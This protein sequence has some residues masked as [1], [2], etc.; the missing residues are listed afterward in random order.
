MHQF[1]RFVGQDDSKSGIDVAIA[2]SGPQ[3][4]VRHYG[5]ITDRF[6]VLLKPVRRLGPR[7]NLLFGT[8]AGPCGY[9]SYRLL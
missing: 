7:E 6:E 4:E 9:E 2:E 5:N 3:G 1:K 8:E